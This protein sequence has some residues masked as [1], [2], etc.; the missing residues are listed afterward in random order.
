[1]ARASKA[2]T[3]SDR[4]VIRLEADMRAKLQEGQA[5]SGSMTLPMCG[6]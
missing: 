3:K 4:I 5:R 2:T 6:C 1:M